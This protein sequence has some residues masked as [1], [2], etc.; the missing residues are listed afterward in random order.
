M[1]ATNI[2]EELGPRNVSLRSLAEAECDGR[3][4]W[5]AYVN[6]AIVGDRCLKLVLCGLRLP[7]T[8][9]AWGAA[10]TCCGY[11]CIEHSHLAVDGWN[12]Y[13][14]HSLVALPGRLSPEA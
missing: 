12:R 2:S 13:W 6:R 11:A 14:Q 8:G 10:V 7:A 4:K 9:M 5:A 3:E 1:L